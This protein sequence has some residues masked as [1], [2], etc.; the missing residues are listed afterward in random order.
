MLNLKK[1]IT[2]CVACILANGAHAGKTQVLVAAT[3]KLAVLLSEKCGEEGVEVAERL[4]KSFGQETVEALSKV[5]VHTPR[6]NLYLLEDLARHLSPEQL[7][8]FSEVVAKHPDFFEIV[9]QSQAFEL[10]GRSPNLTEALYF[11][12]KRAP[13]QQ[14]V[15]IFEHVRGLPGGES[16]CSKLIPALSEEQI[17][18][19]RRVIDGKTYSSRVVDEVIVVSKKHLTSDVS[20]ELTEEIARCAVN[21][22]RVTGVLL[23]EGT[24]TIPGKLQTRNGIDLIGATPEGKPLIVEITSGKNFAD[25]EDVQGLIQM[26][27]GWVVDRWNRFLVASPDNTRKL[28]LAGIDSKYLKPVTVEMVQRDFSRKILKPASAQLERFSKTGMNGLQDIINF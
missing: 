21:G 4:S 12:L 2:V 16:I 3:E 23:K 10:I 8:S 27:D 7:I 24:Q 20:G 19:L 26:T 17:I 5:A 22:R 15:E 9:H 11:S 28:A 1:I 13:G 6:N 18:H 25:T 14:T